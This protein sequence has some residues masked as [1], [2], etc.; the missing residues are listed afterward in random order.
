MSTGARRGAGETG[1]G[2]AGVVFALLLSTA[3]LLMVWTW[4]GGVL[5]AV[6][7]VVPI[8]AVLLFCLWGGDRAP[9]EAIGGPWDGARVPARTVGTDRDVVVLRA[10]GGGD[11]RYAVVGARDLVYRGPGGTVD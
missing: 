11:A 3:T 1:S 2:R 10:P 4:T 9:Y 5:F 7:S 6:V 8:L